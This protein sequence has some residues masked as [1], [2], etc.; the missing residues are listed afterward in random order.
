MKKYFLLLDFDGTLTPIVSR[1]RLAKLSA[2]R[3]NVL[4][5]LAKRKDLA[6]AIVSGRELDDLKRRV[7][8]KDVIYIG[9]HGF[10]IEAGNRLVVHPIA[11]KSQKL[12]ERVYKELKAAM[13]I[14]G[15]II[16]N[17]KYTLSVHYRRVKPGETGR[18][19]RIFQKVT[20][21]Y[22][23]NKKIKVTGG[24][25]VF[26]VRPN[27]VWDKGKAVAWLLERY[28][29]GNAIPVYIG[30]DTTDEDA[31]R[32]LNDKGETILVGRKKTLARRRLAS[33]EAVYKLLKELLID[34]RI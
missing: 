26:E 28:N 25:K 31:F 29:K 11:R 7:G 34:G 21:P 14:A 30:D 18:V 8:L 10:Q 6:V 16:E 20:R 17:K 3:K 4:T 1:P 12:M 32:Y 2:G 13:N 23:A 27:V 24:K 5:K 19:K 15:V 22:L 9:N 33:I